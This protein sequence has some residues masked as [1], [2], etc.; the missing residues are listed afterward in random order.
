LGVID[1]GE[2]GVVF[3]RGDIGAVVPN[4]ANGVGSG[5]SSVGREDACVA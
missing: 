3:L 4:I 2:K 1:L 5:V